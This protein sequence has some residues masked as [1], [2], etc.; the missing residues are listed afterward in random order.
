M[1]RQTHAYKGDLVVRT[2]RAYYQGNA[3]LGRMVKVN[4]GDGIRLQYGDY[5][6][7]AQGHWRHA[8]EDEQDAYN[9]GVR[10][11]QNVQKK[12]IDHFSII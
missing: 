4:G 3:K 8:T 1:G 12:S 5:I 11:A 9:I 7:L 10:Y 2:G 6:E